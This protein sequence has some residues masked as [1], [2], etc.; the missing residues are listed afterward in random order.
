M[1]TSYFLLTLVLTFIISTV[2]LLTGFGV[3]SVLTPTF[4]LFYDV[5][6]AVFLVSIVHLGNNVLKF[7]LFAKHIDTRILM[8]FGFVSV[9]GALLGSLLQG[10]FQTSWVRIALAAFLI[11]S[12]GSEFLFQSS[13]TRISQKYDLFGGFFS[14]LMGG[15]IGNQG[16][17]R[18]A[19]LLNYDLTKEA[20]VAT[21]TS[22]AILIDLTR[23]PVYIYQQAEQEK[24]AWGTLTVVIIIAFAGTFVGKQLLAKVS[25]EQFRKF[26]AAFLILFGVFLLFEP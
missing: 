25:L 13:S 22:I 18:S 14:G 23:I 3:G 10:S 9:T 24:T 7:G 15:L 6:T 5:K 17:I 8:R 26:V 19:Y 16:A 4:T 2:T 12:G 1:T 21:A 11:V 20:F